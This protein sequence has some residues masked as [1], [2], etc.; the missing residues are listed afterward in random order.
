MKLTRRK[1]RPQATDG[2]HLATLCDVQDLGIQNTNFGERHN[3]R[4]IFLIDELDPK[5]EPLQVSLICTASAHENSKLTAL[6]RLLL[7]DQ[8]TEDVD[9]SDLLGRSCCLTTEQ[10][11]NSR[12]KVFAQIVSQRALQPG[13]TP[14]SI[15][16]DFERNENRATSKRKVNGI[17]KPFT[18]VHGLEITDEDVP[19]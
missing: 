7:G 14:P 19:L 9:T 3:L 1:Q 15:P 17:T 12:G 4:L 5:G 13:E 6:T 16:I 2:P 10:Q 18:N 11:A 8:A